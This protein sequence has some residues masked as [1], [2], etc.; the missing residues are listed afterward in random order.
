MWLDPALHAPYELGSR[1]WSHTLPITIGTQPPPLA[2]A[3][4]TIACRFAAVTV[5]GA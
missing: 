1:V 4:L 5:P 3:L 2:D